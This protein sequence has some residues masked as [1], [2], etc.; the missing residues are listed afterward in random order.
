MAF[1]LN[2]N[3]GLERESYQDSRSP[4]I[5]LNGARALLNWAADGAFGHH[6]RRTATAHSGDLSAAHVG[7]DENPA[8]AA[9]FQALINRPS[10]GAIAKAIVAYQ[11]LSHGTGRRARGR[12]FGHTIAG[13]KHASMYVQR[14]GS[15]EDVDFMGWRCGQMFA[16][17]IGAEKG[18]LNR[19]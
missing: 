5:D 3:K 11:P 1:L 2:L 17:K 12:V 16:P 14:I 8:G 13:G 6:H 15:R 18:A 7:F 19:I 10:P 9:N 4:T